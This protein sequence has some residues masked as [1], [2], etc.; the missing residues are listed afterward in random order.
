MANELRKRH[1]RAF[2]AF[3]MK[4]LLD[5]Q[6]LSER[7]RLSAKRIKRHLRAFWAVALK[8]LF[9]EQVLSECEAYRLS[10]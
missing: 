3:A 5:E 9:N 4:R 2:L 7:V 8:R 1:L 6:T 10:G